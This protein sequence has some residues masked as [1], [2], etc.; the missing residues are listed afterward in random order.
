[1]FV[2]RVFKYIVH[3]LVLVW[4]K[5]EFWRVTTLTS[6]V[7]IPIINIVTDKKRIT[8]TQSAAW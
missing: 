4:K 5:L 7:V 6:F 1:V 2:K 8:C 3:E